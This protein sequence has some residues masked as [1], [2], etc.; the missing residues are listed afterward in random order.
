MNTG[1]LTAAQHALENNDSPH[2]KNAAK[3]TCVRGHPYTPENTYNP[4]S[5]PHTRQCR[6][7]IRMHGAKRRAQ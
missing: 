7:C 2:A 3:T 4:P 1:K 6:T 5:A